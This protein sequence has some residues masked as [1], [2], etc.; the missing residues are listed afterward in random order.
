[1]GRDCGWSV[2]FVYADM[3]WEQLDRLV[4][5]YAA[6][7]AYVADLRELEHRLSHAVSLV[8]E[9]RLTQS[10]FSTLLSGRASRHEEVVRKVA[11]AS[12]HCFA[13]R[14]WCVGQKLFTWKTLSTSPRRQ[15]NTNAP[16]GL[17]E[18][19]LFSPVLA[20]LNL[21]GH[22]PVMP[23]SDSTPAVLPDNILVAK[24]ERVD[25]V[26]ASPGSEKIV[27][28]KGC[29]YSQAKRLS[30][31]LWVNSDKSNLFTDGPRF[32]AHLRVPTASVAALLQARDF[33]QSV[34]PA[35]SV[36]AHYMVINDP[37]CSWHFQAHNLTAMPTALASTSSPTLSLDDSPVSMSFRD[38]PRA[39]GPE[40]EDLAHLPQWSTQDLSTVLPLD[41]PSR[42]LLLLAE[43]WTIQ[44]NKP[45]RLM[46]VRGSALAKAVEERSGIAYPKDMVRHD[47]EDCLERGRFIRRAANGD[48][49]FA[50]LP[51]GVARLLVL[52]HKYH[53]STA[54]VPS[55]VIQQVTLLARL[56]AAT[57]VA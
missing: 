48:N 45:G 2:N 40:G 10:D 7:S 30:P 43:L 51:K 54:H 31:S 22:C 50:V 42:A 4:E 47:L 35:A 39:F 34:L 46:W 1:M 28:V 8:T 38:F 36:T 27:L 16:D 26:L 13:M 25:A 41:R 9:S 19:Q 20:Q 33:L 56:W 44:A 32:I 5:S 29:S 55:M 11:W 23:A 14:A 3:S 6:A 17:T 57:P 52:K 24:G 21:L 37:D 15:R 18:Q 53:R 12:Q 49:T